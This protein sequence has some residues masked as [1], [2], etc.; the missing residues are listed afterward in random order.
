MVRANMTVLLGSY[1]LKLSVSIV[2][3]TKGLFT[4][5]TYVGARIEHLHHS[6]NNPEIYTLYSKDRITNEI[7]P[8]KWLSESIK[9]GTY[10]IN[11]GKLKKKGIVKNT[12]NN[13]NFIEIRLTILSG[14]SRHNKSR[15]CRTRRSL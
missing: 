15:R 6:N 9:S 1:E 12:E 3:H 5:Q 11:Y 10:Y 14:G 4:P 2:P 13:S 7:Q 8:V